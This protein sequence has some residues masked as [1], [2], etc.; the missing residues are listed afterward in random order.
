MVP[1][2][3]ILTGRVTALTPQPRT[4]QTRAG[5]LQALRGCV[6]STPRSDWPCESC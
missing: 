5:E 3:A 6:G 4:V 1:Q 2:P